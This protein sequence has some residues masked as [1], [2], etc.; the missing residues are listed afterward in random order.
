MCSLFSIEIPEIPQI[1]GLVFRR[2]RDEADLLNIAA[3]I[4]ASLAADKNSE[5]ITAERLSHIFAHPIHWDPQQDTL[6]VDVNDIL[7]GYANTEWRYQDDGDCFHSINLY[8]VPQW[9]VFDPSHSS[10]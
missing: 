9:L 2:F 5:R 10:C 4:N 7:I 3:V 8:L 1:S 6:L